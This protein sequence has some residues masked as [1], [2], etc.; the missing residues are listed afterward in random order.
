MLEDAT[1]TL[2][3]I[4]AK[5]K[6]A[7]YRPDVTPSS[8]IKIKNPGYSQGE[9]SGRAIRT[10]THDQRPTSFWKVATAFTAGGMPSR[11]R[12]ARPA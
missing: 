4:V 8:W 3:S 9:G 12:S 6:A 2:E 1:S 10:G 11:V 7:P 5:W